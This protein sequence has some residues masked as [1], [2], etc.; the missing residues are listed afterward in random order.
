MRMRLYLAP[1]DRHRPTTWVAALGAVVSLALL[2]L[3]LPP[4]DLH[5]PWHHLGLMDPL[6]GGTRSAR[7]TMEGDLAEAWRYNPLGIAAVLAAFAVLGRAAL[8]VVSG[9]WVDVR[10][11]STRTATRILWTLA[12]STFIALGVRQQ[13]IADLLVQQG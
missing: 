7:L 10:V 13:L 11:R 9:R 6:C 5:G 2:T 3:G 1:T 8:G 12:A 4:I